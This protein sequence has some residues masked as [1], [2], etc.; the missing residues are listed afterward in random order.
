MTV[1]GHGGLIDIQGVTVAQVD[2]QVRLQK[3]E[4]WF[5]PMEMFRQIA[6]KGLT[7]ENL[8]EPESRPA[9]QQ[10]NEPTTDVH[11]IGQE[12]KTDPDNATSI[13]RDGET[14][15]VATSGDGVE[16]K[17]QLATGSEVPSGIAL[18][19]QPEQEAVMGHEDMSKAMSTGCPF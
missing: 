10:D 8:T 13:P 14:K 17:V 9:E 3:V 6:P 7:D 5:D 1:K 15:T 4:T 18:T 2:E 19:E 16:E 12:D 11:S